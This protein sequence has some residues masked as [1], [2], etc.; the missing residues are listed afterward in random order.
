MKKIN[1]LKLQHQVNRLEYQD[2][3]R[4]NKLDGLAANREVTLAAQKYK[5]AKD[6]FNL[7]QQ[8]YQ[9]A[10]AQYNN[11]RLLIGDFY[12]QSYTYEQEKNNYLNASYDFILARMKQEKAVK[13]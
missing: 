8:N 3:Q 1:Q 7:A 12:K 9:N 11:G 10:Q 6:N 4:K 2:Q 13:N 5:R